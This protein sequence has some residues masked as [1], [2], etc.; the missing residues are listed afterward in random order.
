[1]SRRHFSASEKEVR[2]QAAKYRK[3]LEKLD[4]WFI[5]VREHHASR[6]QCGFGCAK[7][8]HGL[9]DV[10]LA[11]ALMI[12]EGLAGLPASAVEEIKA[13][14]ERIQQKIVRG[15]PE[16]KSPYFLHPLS[17][18]NIDRITDQVKDAACPFLGEQNGCLIYSRRPIACRLEGVPMI[19]GLD[20]LFGD[21]CD[22][23]FVEGPPDSDEDLR[24]DY[25]GIQ[26]IEREMTE[27]LSRHLLGRK[28]ERVTIFI[29]SLVTT[30]DSFW[31]R[32]CKHGKG[33]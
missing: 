22:L 13:R 27:C 15:Y 21:W 10:S 24:L 2:L 7:C 4:A 5:S 26:E 28:Q 18:E 20:G 33:L 8:C 14:S 9:F 1:M 23:N 32:W 30:F 25:Y 19:D 6:M 12:A 17:E 16:L 29:P 31:Q 3:L 11:D